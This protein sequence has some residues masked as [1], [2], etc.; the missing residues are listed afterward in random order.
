MTAI[1]FR[2]AARRDL[3]AIYLFTQHRFGTIQAER[4]VT[5]ISESCGLVLAGRRQARSEA[6]MQAGLFSHRSGSHRIYHRRSPDGA[7]IVVRIL[8]EAMNHQ[9]H[10]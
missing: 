1:E 10:L 3:A 9:D 8:H 2:P 6:A 7:L 4:Y 5:A